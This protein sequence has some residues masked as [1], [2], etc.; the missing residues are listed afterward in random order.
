MVTGYL[1]K[2]DPVSRE[3]G[4]EENGFIEREMRATGKTLID[5]AERSA[6]RHIRERWGT[7]RFST[8]GIQQE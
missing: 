1:G 6:Y 8:T 5:P 7:E 2:W 4:I 3:H